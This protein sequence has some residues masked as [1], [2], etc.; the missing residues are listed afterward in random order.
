MYWVDCEGEDY[1]ATLNTCLEYYADYGYCDGIQSAD[2]AMCVLEATSSCDY[3][4]YDSCFYDYPD[5][6]ASCN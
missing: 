3:G 6:L 4:Q 2:Y 5:A 1:T